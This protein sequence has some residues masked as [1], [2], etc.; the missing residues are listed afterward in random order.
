MDHDQEKTV[1]LIHHS[2]N[3][4]SIRHEDFIAGIAKGL[5][6]LEC[7]GP[8]RHRLNISTAAEK[9]GMTRAAA[10]RHLLT[11]EYL[12]YL[13]FDGHYYYLALKF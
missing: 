12:G 10:R 4:K 3:K 8:E 13:E 2:E 9:T 1:R 5:T 11:L 6:I 7:F